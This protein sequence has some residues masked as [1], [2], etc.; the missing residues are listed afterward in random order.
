LK[1]DQEQNTRTNVSSKI[2]EIK[3]SPDNYHNQTPKVRRTTFGEIIIESP[4]KIIKKMKSPFIEV[5][6]KFFLDPTQ[7]QTPV[8]KFQ[9][10]VKK[11]NELF[12]IWESERDELKSAISSKNHL[13]ENNIADD[14]EVTVLSERSEIE[15]PD[16][17]KSLFIAESEIS[18]EL[19]KPLSS[20]KPSLRCN[21]MVR[22]NHAP[23]IMLSETKK[24]PLNLRTSSRRGSVLRP[25]Y[26][27]EKSYKPNQRLLTPCIKILSAINSPSVNSPIKLSYDSKPMAKTPEKIFQRKRYQSK[28][29]IS[30]K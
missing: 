15:K 5:G 17:N 27:P 23:N 24:M 13:S 7:Y 11:K 6:P 16:E 4:K 14:L 9:I 29:E 18:A 1:F 25:S 12:L 3:E 8:K 26:S 22:R 21:S 2:E 30:I 10:N 19:N 20:L 28:G